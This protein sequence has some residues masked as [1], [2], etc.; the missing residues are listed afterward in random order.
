MKLIVMH[1][2]KGIPMR[3]WC[4]TFSLFCASQGYPQELQVLN[5]NTLFFQDSSKIVKVA[6]IQETNGEF[7]QGYA[8][9]SASQVFYAFNYYDG[10]E[11]CTLMRLFDLNTRHE[12]NFGFLG[13]A[14]GAFFQYSRENAHLI[15]G[16]NDRIYLASL[17][18][19][20]WIGTEK[21]GTREIAVLSGVRDVLPFWMGRNTVGYVDY[22][23]DNWDIKVIQISE[24]DLR[25]C[26]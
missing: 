5:K 12:R 23:S 2:L 26:K 11:P 10:G 18:S 7:F 13:N 25:G 14:F 22:S 15:F 3:F 8:M 20:E 24:H 19:I 17:D 4:F 16:L 1:S 9:T 21:Y 6:R